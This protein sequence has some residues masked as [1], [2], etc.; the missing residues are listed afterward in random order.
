MYTNY[1][2]FESSAEALATGASPFDEL[3]PFH[4]QIVLTAAFGAFLM[5]AFSLGHSV[6]T[7]ML[8]P[9]APS[10]LAFFPSLHTRRI[11][12]ITSVRS[13]WLYGWHRLFARLFLISGVW[14]GEWPERKLTDKEQEQPADLGKVLGGFTSSV[15]IHGFAVRGV[16]GGS[17]KDAT[18]EA[19][20]FLLNGAATN[21]EEFA[22]SLVLSWRKHDQRT[23]AA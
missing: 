16:L 23:G 15:F 11:W 2:A 20:F 6:F 7:I 14:P 13:F 21:V 8:S 3:L 22:S 12:D 17:W 1:L 18:G 9:L 10:P 4:L 19:E 5:A